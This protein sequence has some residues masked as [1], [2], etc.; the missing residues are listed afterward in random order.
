ME[1]PLRLPGEGVH[2]RSRRSRL[3]FD[4]ALEAVGFRRGEAVAIFQGDKDLLEG[5]SV[6]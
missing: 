5:V 6:K 2:D 4:H 1:H 3:K